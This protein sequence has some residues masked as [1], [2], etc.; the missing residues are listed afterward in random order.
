VDGGIP[1]LLGG[2]DEPRPPPGLDGQIRGRYRL[3]GAETV[4]ARALVGLKLKQLQQPGPFRGGG[5]HLQAPALVG[6]KQSGRSHI[7]K[8]DAVLDQACSRSATSWSDTRLSASSTNVRVSSCSRLAH[9][10]GDSH[11]LHREDKQATKGNSA[12]AAANT[13]HRAPD[14]AGKSGIRTGVPVLNACRPGPSPRANSRSATSAI[15]SS[16]AHSRSRDASEVIAVNTPPSIGNVA[17]KAK[18]ASPAGFAPVLSAD[19]IAAATT[20][21]NEKRSFVRQ[22]LRLSTGPAGH[23]VDLSARAVTG[24]IP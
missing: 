15:V 16:L 18:H 3:S 6:Q 2:L 7:Q 5:H 4:Q 21:R 9:T 22:V 8:T 11:D 23:D 1:L 20:P 12:A 13:G 14:A 24:S 19:A 17:T 10:N